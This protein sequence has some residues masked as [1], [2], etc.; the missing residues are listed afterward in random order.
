MYTFNACCA[1]GCKAYALTGGDFCIDHAADAEETRISLE[2]RLIAETLI[3][4][5]N[6]G[7]LSYSGTNLSGKHIATS[8][9]SGAAFTDVDF[10]SSPALFKKYTQLTTELNIRKE[11]Y[12]LLR[13]ELEKLK[14]EEIKDN[15]FIEVLDAA[16]APYKK[17]YPERRKITAYSFCAGFL[18]SCLALLVFQFL[19]SR[20]LQ[21]F[22]STASREHD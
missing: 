12:T 11:K 19:R 7:G 14:I 2:R 4:D 18:V 22:L 8:R 20:N 16:Q 1:K 5:I 3:K 6:A 17:R 15:P 9:F 13:L 21:S 10:S